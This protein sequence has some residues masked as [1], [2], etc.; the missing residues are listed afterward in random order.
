MGENRGKY[1]KNEKHFRKESVMMMMMMMM[2]VELHFAGTLKGRTNVFFQPFKAHMKLF[3]NRV[4]PGY[5]EGLNYNSR[6]QTC[7]SVDPL[8]KKVIQQNAF[9]KTFQNLVGIPACFL[10]GWNIPGAPAKAIMSG[11]FGG[12]PKVYTCKN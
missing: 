1:E 9:L 4:S 12:G 3:Q 7:T 8:F 5:I 6:I 2:V 10:K 11:S